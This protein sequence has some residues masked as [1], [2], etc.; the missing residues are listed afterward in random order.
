MGNETMSSKW[1]EVEKKYY[2]FTVRRQPVVIARGAGTRV[3]DV[4]GKEYLDFVAGWAVNNIGHCNPAV[5]RA[6]AEQATTLIQTSN[7]FYTVPQLKLA[8]LLIENSCL[9]KVFFGNSGAEANE[10][11]VKLARK[12]G[13]KNKG[14]ANEIITA[15]NSF[16]GRTMNMVA[17]T[18]QP[19][20]QENF[21][22][23]PPG[24]VH[25]PYND[26][27]AIKQ[28]TNDKTIAV[29]LEPVQ[30]EAGVVIPAD[31]YL[32]RV[33]EWCDQKGL[34]LMLDEVQ[35]GFGR[36]GSLFGYQE[37]GIEPDVMTLAKGLGAGVPIGAFLS[38]DACMALEPGDHGSTFGGNVLTTAAA[39]AS[40]K[41]IIDND[42][43]G[44]AR[45]MGAYFLKGLNELKSRFSFV[46][47][48][49]GKG[50]LL[51][52]EF[53]DNLTPKVV[54]A[55]NQAGLL[56][57]PVKPNAIRFMPPLTIST[58]EIDEGLGRLEGVLKKL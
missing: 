48:A 31:D 35:T 23:L 43:P 2:M 24:F 6:I 17:A 57:N 32:K 39:Y 29:L 51:A 52:L 54:P 44:R 34:L 8:Q 20:Y 30:G 4:D 56:L 28:A 36:I 37:Y 27:D 33:R 1:I 26:V 7:Q 47:D 14:G 41:Y 19:H 3:W 13:R 53:N 45:K 46:T 16:H 25:V 9:D 42:I 11:A 15:L 10:G 55:C 38:K 49:R 5:A 40:T 21:K 22:P 50:L 18:G 12:F 58:E